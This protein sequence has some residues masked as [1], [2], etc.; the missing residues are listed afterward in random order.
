MHG[1]SPSNEFE[2]DMAQELNPKIGRDSIPLKIAQHSPLSSKIEKDIAQ[3]GRLQNWPSHSP[4][5]NCTAFPLQMGWKTMWPKMVDPKIAQEIAPLRIAQHSPFH[6]KYKWTWPK[7]VDP[8]IG[9]GTA[10]QKI[11]QHFPFKW[12][13]KRCGPKW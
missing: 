12:D 2:N 10:P 8:K 4:T 7:M 11:A 13:G 9:P 5:K 6:I 1:I 3:D